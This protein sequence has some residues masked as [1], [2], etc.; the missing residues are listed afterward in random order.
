MDAP[1]EGPAKGQV[2]LRHWSTW[3]TQGDWESLGSPAWGREG[4]GRPEQCV[5]VS[6]EGGVEDKVRL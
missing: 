3:H 1:G 4:S 2:C 6:H 5:Q